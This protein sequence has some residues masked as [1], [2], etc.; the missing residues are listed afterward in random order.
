PEF[1][2]G[3]P[4]EIFEAGGDELGYVGDLKFELGSGGGISVGVSDVAEHSGVSQTACRFLEVVVV[5]HRTKLQAA[6]GGD[7]V[8]REALATRDFD[9]DQL[10]F[11]SRNLREGF[12]R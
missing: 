7:G 11:R 1:S 8:L 12:L 6:R 4:Y 5:D 3:E 9:G 2:V 10:S